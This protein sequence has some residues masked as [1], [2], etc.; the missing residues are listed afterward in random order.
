MKNTCGTE[1]YAISQSVSYRSDFWGNGKKCTR[2]IQNVK[3]K[4]SSL[5]PPV[6]QHTSPP[7]P[8]ISSY[9]IRRNWLLYVSVS[10]VN[11]L[12]N[13]PTI[14]QWY[15]AIYLSSPSPVHNDPVII[16]P[17]P[18]IASVES[19]VSCHERFWA[20]GGAVPPPK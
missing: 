1:I 15:L 14:Y 9:L 10:I 20:I 7:A 18:R 4:Y 6:Q 13:H 3:N 5:L 19:I 17:I 12:T 11:F 2:T 16:L 8:R